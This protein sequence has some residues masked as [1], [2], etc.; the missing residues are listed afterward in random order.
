MRSPQA[1]LS[2]YS[3]P[4]LYTPPSPSMP[5]FFI[6]SLN[7]YHLSKSILKIYLFVFYTLA[8]QSVIC[9]TA[10]CLHTVLDYECL[11]GRNEEGIIVFSYKNRFWSK[12]L[13]QISF[14]P[15]RM[16]LGE[17]FLCL[18]ILCPYIRPIRP[19]SPL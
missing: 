1:T 6:C 19:E 8:T 3:F 7:T 5:V 14:P 18:S 13:C 2:Y 4:Y 10:S 15:Y 16:T 17:L 11:Q 9:G 12:K